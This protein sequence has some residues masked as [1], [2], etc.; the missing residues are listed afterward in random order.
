MRNKPQMRSS[1][2]SN[3]GRIANAAPFVT[4]AQSDPQGPGVKDM[5]E[6]IFSYFLMTQQ[7]RDSWLQD[8]PPPIRDFVPGLPSGGPTLSPWT[9]G[10]FAPNPTRP[11]FWPGFVTPTPGARV[12]PF[13]VR[14]LPSP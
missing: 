8:I 2:R 13:P 4:Q 5:S 6:A 11:A 1:E 3:K 12:T 7:Q 14:T 9:V 10:P